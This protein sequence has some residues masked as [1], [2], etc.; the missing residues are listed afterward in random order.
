[1]FMTTQDDDSTCEQKD[2]DE[3]TLDAYLQTKTTNYLQNWVNT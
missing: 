1:M 2:L 3:N